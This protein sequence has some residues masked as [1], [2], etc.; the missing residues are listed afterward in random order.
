MHPLLKNILDPP[1][2]T[3]N[4]LV[5]EAVSDS[6]RVSGQNRKIPPALGTNQIAGFGGLRPLAARKLGKR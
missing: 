5:N 4:K 1:L 3:T 2:Q 6:A